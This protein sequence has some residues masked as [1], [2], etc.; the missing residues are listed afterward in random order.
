MLKKT[1]VLFYP[2]T[3]V[4]NILKLFDQLQDDNYYRAFC[5]VER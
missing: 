2:E 5:M 4:L 1:L 3:Y